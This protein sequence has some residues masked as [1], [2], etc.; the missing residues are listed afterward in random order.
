M[1]KRRWAFR[2]WYQLKAWYLPRLTK[3][4]LIL[5]VLTQTEDR[6]VRENASEELSQSQLAL[7]S[8]LW[9]IFLINGWRGNPLWV[10][11]IFGQVV[12]D[13]K[14]NSSMLSLLNS[15]C[16]Q[17]LALMSLSD[18]QWFRHISQLNPFLPKLLLVWVFYYSNSNLTKILPKDRHSHYI[19]NQHSWYIETRY[20]TFCKIKKCK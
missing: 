10:V 15:S 16:L 12:Q 3:R 14:K 18:R 8:Y 13:C 11:P 6:W 2:K 17:V 5:F 1:Q 7:R 4:W 9:G 19:I 20:N